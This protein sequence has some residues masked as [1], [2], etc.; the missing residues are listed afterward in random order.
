[1]SEKDANERDQNFPLDR[2]KQFEKILYQDG[3]TVDVFKVIIQKQK[4]D[5]QRPSISQLKIGHILYKKMNV[6]SEIIDTKKIGRNRIIV[7]CRN[8]ATAN[9]I[10]ESEELKI[11]HEVFIPFSF[12]SRAA[13][14]R[15]VD[16]EYTDEELK[17][18]IETGPYKILS[19]KRMRRRMFNDG[20]VTFG[21]SRSVKVFFEGSQFPSAVYLWGVRLTCEPFTP[22]LIQCFRCLRYNHTTNQC[23]S[24]RVCK[25]C[26]TKQEQEH[27][28]QG[29]M[30]INCK[31]AHTA[32]SQ[33]CPEKKKKKIQCRKIGI[34]CKVWK[35]SNLINECSVVEWH[36]SYVL[37]QSKGMA[38]KYIRKNALLK[39]FCLSLISN[40]YICRKRFLAKVQMSLQLL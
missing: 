31:G 4:K 1:M 23:K 32:D 26:G 35:I 40:V 29:E 38:S 20:A 28:C 22:P 33:E 2:R 36:S 5:E 24:Q 15:D 30:C 39:K 27:V 10:V 13:V 11:E 17:N 14:I 9:K 34:K 19:V 25:V 37:G 12:I 18:E 21:D 8:G 7:N 6:G 16:V 3:M